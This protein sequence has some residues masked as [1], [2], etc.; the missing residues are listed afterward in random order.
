MA[1]AV[2]NWNRQPRATTFISAR[3]LHAKILAADVAGNTAGY[4]TVTN[5]PPGG[6]LSSSSWSLVEVHAPTATISPGTPNLYFG[7]HSNVPSLLTADFNND[8]IVDLALG[9]G[10]HKITIRLGD[11]KAGFN[12]ASTATVAYAANFFGYNNAAYGDFDDDGNLD[13]AFQTSFGRFNPTGI[14]VNLGNG[15]GTFR[16]G[17][18]LQDSTVIGVLAGD[19]NG[20]G[21]LD[22]IAGD[23]CNTIVFLGNGDGTFRLFRRYKFGADL[24]LAGDFNGDGKLDLVLRGGVDDNFAILVALGNGDGTFQR[25]HQIT[26]TGGRCGFSPPMLVNDFNGDGN[27]DVAFCT[28]TSIG[29]LLGNGDGTFQRPVF[30]RAGSQGAFSFAAGDFNSDGK[31]DLIVSHSGVDF[32]FSTLLGNGDGTFQHKFPVWLSKFAN[33]ELGI[34]TGDFNSDGLL[35]F[36]FQFGG[37]GIGVYP[38]K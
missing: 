33:G 35:D 34:V 3:E 36:A 14:G 2:V 23:C 15:D 4:I 19:F 9:E 12:F 31:T 16:P 20:D 8:G 22:L 21:K 11:G 7:G 6:G 30:Y 29:I 38:Q 13:L 18:R 1:G 17:W 27:L 10:D 32:Q 24:R 37:S 25:P 26:A 28:Q 5:P